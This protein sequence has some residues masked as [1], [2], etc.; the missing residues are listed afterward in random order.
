[1]SYFDVFYHALASLA[2]EQS[3]KACLRRSTS[4]SRTA[5]GYGLYGAPNGCQWVGVMLELVMRL[6]HA[7]LIYQGTWYTDG[8][9]GLAGPRDL[10]GCAQC[11]GADRVVVT[12]CAITQ[13]TGWRISR[14]LHKSL[15]T[16]RNRKICSVGCFDACSTLMLHAAHPDSTGCMNCGKWV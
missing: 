8:S 3:P 6:G 11:E 10:H 14:G 2:C 1:M 16:R 12:E 5:R 9:Q 7:W 15:E 13:L 4:V